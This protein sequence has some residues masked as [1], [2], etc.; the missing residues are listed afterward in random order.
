MYCPNCGIE[1]RGPSKFCRSCGAELDGVRSTMR[2]ADAITDSAASARHEIGR[3][4]AAKIAEVNTARELEKISEKI[5]PAIE[6]FLESPEERR[7][8][9]CR[10]GV[11]TTAAGL[12]VGFI[13]KLIYI[14]VHD[15]QFFALIGGGMAVMTFLIGL[16]MIINGVLFTVP[17]KRHISKSV[18]AGEGDLAATSHLDAPD[19][20]DFIAPSVT[21]GTTHHLKPVS[22]K[23]TDPI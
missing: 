23:S 2:R 3:A 22:I 10:E 1:E 19:Q 11:L 13:S 12:G 17:R 14:F 5:L 18:L 7:L 4:L 21:E 8:R 15:A 9:Q 6:K 16:G 20:R